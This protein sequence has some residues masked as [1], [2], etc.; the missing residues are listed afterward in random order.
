MQRKIMVHSFSIDLSF[1]KLVLTVCFLSILFSSCKSLKL[2][3]SDEFHI[4][5]NLKLGYHTDVKYF[6]VGVMFMMMT[7]SFTEHLLHTPPRFY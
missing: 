6:Q 5:A 7:L 1:A 4:A 2:R 3:K